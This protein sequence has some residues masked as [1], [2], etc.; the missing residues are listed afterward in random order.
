MSKIPTQPAKGDTVLFCDHADKVK[1]WHWWYIRSLA[2]GRPNGT[3][4][5]AQWILACPKCF[6]ASGGKALKVPVAGDTVW[7]GG[8]PLIFEKKS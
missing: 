4:G 3:I 1:D 2:F 8:K 5:V 6:L 7:D